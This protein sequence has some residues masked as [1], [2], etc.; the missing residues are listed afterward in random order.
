M[1][2]LGDV[3]SLGRLWWSVSIYVGRAYLVQEDGFR[4]LTESGDP[5]IT[6]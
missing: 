2:G 6:E 3:G 1:F 5:L 4:I